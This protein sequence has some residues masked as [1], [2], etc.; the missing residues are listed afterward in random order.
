M[1][2]FGLLLNMHDEGRTQMIK[3]RWVT[4]ENITR[5]LIDGTVTEI[6]FTGD[7]FVADDLEPSGWYGMKFAKEFD[8]E[9]M[10]FGSWGGGIAYS[11]PMETGVMGAIKNFFRHEF[12]WEIY[13]DTYICCEAEGLPLVEVYESDGL[14]TVEFNGDV[15]FNKITKDRAEDIKWALEEG[16][17]YGKELG[18]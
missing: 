15:V 14:Y 6:N 16:I 8:K 12:D 5:W 9:T 1:K 10:I 3:Y 17:K 2:T 4:L 13:H 18:A 11:D 7:A